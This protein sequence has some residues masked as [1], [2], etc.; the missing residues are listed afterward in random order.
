M[1]QISW[2]DFEKVEMCV[3]TIIKVEDFPEAKKPT[4][5]LTVDF[6]DKGI[7]KSSSRIVDLYKKEDL[8]GKQI[9]GVINF[10]AKQIGPFLSEFLTTG[11]YRDDGSVVLVVPDKDV[12]NG[13]KIG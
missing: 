3:G 8:I 6:G 13:A 2:D 9:V 7:K 5:K 4:Y 11:F 10:P 12:P 1:Q